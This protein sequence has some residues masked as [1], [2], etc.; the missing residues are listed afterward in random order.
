M[1]HDRVL[2]IIRRL[3]LLMDE[4]LLTALPFDL[5]ISVIRSID[6]A[7]GDIFVSFFP[8]ATAALVVVLA[9]FVPAIFIILFVSSS[10]H[11]LAFPFCHYAVS[12]PLTFQCHG[13]FCHRRNSFYCLELFRLR[14]PT[15]PTSLLLPLICRYQRTHTQRWQLSHLRLFVL[16]TIFAFICS[17]AAIMLSTSPS[18]WNMVTTLD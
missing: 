18:L 3:V 6:S 11:L 1:C 17:T 7:D 16:R 15:P 8:P 5:W 13:F 10:S 2:P 12:M 9:L 4:L 14:R